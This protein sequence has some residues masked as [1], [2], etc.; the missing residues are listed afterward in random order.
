MLQISA[1]ILAV[2]TAPLN[3]PPS[4]FGSPATAGSR[5]VARVRSEMAGFT[6][7]L[8]HRFPFHVPVEI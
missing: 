8:H 3:F 7:K 5:G 2:N 4:S 6:V 1:G